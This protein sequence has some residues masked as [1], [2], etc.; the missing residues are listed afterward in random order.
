LVYQL[1]NFQWDISWLRE[2][3]EEILPKN[4]TFDNFEMEHD[5]K[6]IGRRIMLL[7][8]RRISRQTNQT[9]LI[10]L[11]IEDVTERKR[12]EAQLRQAQ[13]ME[14]I[15]TLAGGNAHFRTGP[16]PEPATMLLL[17][18]ELIGLVGFRKRFRK[19]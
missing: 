14:A 8:A 4:M 6:E 12:L 11:A 16:L 18:S 17:A 2:L 5:F 19:K 10:L 3:L 13:K 7:N 9:Q 1:G 15:G